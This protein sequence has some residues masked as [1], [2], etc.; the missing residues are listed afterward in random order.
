MKRVILIELLLITICLS[1]TDGN[2][3]YIAVLDFGSLVLSELELVSITNQF[4]SNLVRLNQF[5]VLNRSKME[6]ILQEQS[7]QLSGCTEEACAVEVGKLLNVNYIF[8]GEVGKIGMTYT[9]DISL[10]N[11]ETGQIEKSYSKSFVGEKDDFLKV[12]EDITYEISGVN[13]RRTLSLNKYIAPIGSVSSAGLGIYSY[14]KSQDYYK[15]HQN[16]TSKTEMEYY[17]NLTIKYR[18]Y[19]KYCTV[20][21]GGFI[22]YYFI[23]K[24]RENKNTN[25]VYLDLPDINNNSIGITLCLKL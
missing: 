10:I 13:Y 25:K 2:K 11:V 21:S 15:Q 22:I 9:I 16:S 24:S 14:L 17:K 23:S 12:L 1:D 7:F 8:I 5:T 19:A 20:A 4:R 3:P 6:I 18:N